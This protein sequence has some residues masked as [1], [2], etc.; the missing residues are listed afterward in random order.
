TY[1]AEYQLM[2]EFFSDLELY[3][4]TALLIDYKYNHLASKDRNIVDNALA[5][6][7]SHETK[8]K[9]LEDFTDVIEPA[10]VIVMW[11]KHFLSDTLVSDPEVIG[12]V[13]ARYIGYED[14]AFNRMYRKRVDE[15]HELSPLW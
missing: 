1:E 7:S 15:M 3:L 12:R 4:R 6:K 10:Y 11:Y 13:L 2:S 8:K 5:T 14:V 9:F